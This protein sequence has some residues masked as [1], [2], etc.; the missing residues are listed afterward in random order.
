MSEKRKPGRPIGSGKDDTRYLLDVADLLAANPTLKKTPAIS[1]IVQGAFP[2]Q[3]WKNAER[4]LL[5]KWNVETD[6]HLEN[7]RQRRVKSDHPLER[8]LEKNLRNLHYALQQVNP[9]VSSL[10]EQLSKAF[11][12]VKHD[13]DPRVKNWAETFGKSANPLN[14]PELKHVF[15]DVRNLNEETHQAN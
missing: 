2:E 15:H 13:I 9:D 4:R 6:K 8:C 11:D 1:K 14:I 10:I 7:A 3:E 5:N 12:A